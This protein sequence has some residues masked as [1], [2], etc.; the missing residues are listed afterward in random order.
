MVLNLATPNLP[1]RNVMVH[2]LEELFGMVAGVED[3][4]ILAD[5]FILGVLTDGTELIAV[6]F[7]Q[8]SLFGNCR[9]DVV[10]IHR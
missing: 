8:V 4:V 2:L 5:Q 3:A 7:P 1:I 9:V 10:M 6:Q